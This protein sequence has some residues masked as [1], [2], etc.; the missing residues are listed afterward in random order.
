MSHLHIAIRRGLALVAV[1]SLCLTLLSPVVWAQGGPDITFHPV[2][3]PRH[4]PAPIPHTSVIPGGTV[5]ASDVGPQSM[6][7]NAAALQQGTAGKPGVLQTATDVSS[8]ITLYNENNVC[9]DFSS[10]IWHGETWTRYFSGW[11][12]YAADGGIYQSKNV[13]FDL[14]RVVGPGEKYGRG[15]SLKIASNQPYQAGVMSPAINV[16]KGQMVHVRAAYLIYNHDAVGR[17]WDFV[18][19]GIIPNIGETATYVDGYRRG[20]WAII[21]EEVMATGPQIVV[22]LQAQSPDALNSNIYFDNVQ[23]FLDGKPVARCRG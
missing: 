21:E 23:I 13:T 14:E 17:N 15:L 9:N 20:E 8:G 1:T 18:S 12:D 7:A 22:M 4:S 3:P 5:Q 19:M 16:K 6:A 11:G 10:G 2:V